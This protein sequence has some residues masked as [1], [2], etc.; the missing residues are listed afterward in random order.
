MEGKL[1]ELSREGVGASL[2]DDDDNDIIRVDENRPG[3]RTPQSRSRRSNLGLDAFNND[4]ISASEN[5]G[6]EVS[7]LRTQPQTRDI[8][9]KEEGQSLDR[10]RPPAN[11]R[12]VGAEGRGRGPTLQGG[13]EEAGRI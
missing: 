1:S 12:P 13:A 7:F 10:T 11:I 5:P 6:P 4:I 9:E 3:D 8:A 2:I